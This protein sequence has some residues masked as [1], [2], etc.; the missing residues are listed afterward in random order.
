M[1]NAVN[2]CL[3]DNCHLTESNDH[4]HLNEKLSSK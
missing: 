1:I 2:S 3:K 4:E